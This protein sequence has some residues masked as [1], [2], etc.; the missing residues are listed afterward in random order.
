[1]TCGGPPPA[2]SATA[3]MEKPT[4]GPPGVAA[5]AITAVATPNQPEFGPSQPVMISCGMTAAI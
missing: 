1:M 5:P 2:F 4:T 3:P